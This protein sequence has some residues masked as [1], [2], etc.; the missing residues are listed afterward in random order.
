[1]KKAGVR[2]A[3]KSR[4]TTTPLD[5][6]NEK[7][8]L[9]AQQ[10]I[11]AIKQNV[12]HNIIDFR[13]D[14]NDTL[15]HRCG[16]LKDESEDRNEVDQN[17]V[18]LKYE[19]HVM[20]RL[21][22][23]GTTVQDMYYKGNR[24]SANS[25]EFSPFF[26]GRKDV[27]LY[28]IVNY[29]HHSEDV[30]EH[31][32]DNVAK[33][34]NITHVRHPFG[35]RR[36]NSES[37]EIPNMFKGKSLYE[38]I[39]GVEKIVS[40]DTPTINNVMKYRKWLNDN[41]YVK[42][43]SSC[44]G[45]LQYCTRNCNTLEGMFDIHPHFFPKWFCDGSQYGKNISMTKA[46]KLQNPFAFIGHYIRSLEKARAGGSEAYIDWMSDVF[47][48]MGKL[49]Y[50]RFKLHQRLGDTL[51]NIDMD[52]NR[53]LYQKVYDYT[54]QYKNKE[55][56]HFHL[57][58]WCISCLSFR[59]SCVRG[60]RF[61]STKLLMDTAPLYEKTT[62]IYMLE[63]L[64]DYLQNRGRDNYFGLNDI[65]NNFQAV[66]LEGNNYGSTFR[67]NTLLTM[68]IDLMNFDV[69][70]CDLPKSPYF[71]LDAYTPN[72]NAMIF[73]KD[74][75]YMNFNELR[76]FGTF[77]TQMT[78]SFTTRFFRNSVGDEQNYKPILEALGNYTD[79]NNVSK[80][81]IDLVLNMY[82]F[83]KMDKQVM[84]K[85]I[86]GNKELQLFTPHTQ[87]LTNYFMNILIKAIMNQ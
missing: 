85:N 26:F 19:I 49:F 39:E 71:D 11:E 2:G 83:S 56:H 80:P 58:C 61:D 57:E 6:I 35:S 8:R 10:P 34:Y 4:T 48:D 33:M 18:Y 66:D 45:S 30:L 22:V 40:E 15:R 17:C 9:I 43:G 36:F 76:R 14:V 87:E 55:F 73:F 32:T 27:I 42:H 65:W 44:D 20:T 28:F 54:K 41:E 81:I 79:I 3:N 31:W 13:I 12:F 50:S 86:L 5:Q 1:M 21:N 72:N 60:M 47:T 78:K 59:H 24:V 74:K 64:R 84:Y 63:E 62:T 53:E 82:E 67:T 16:G 29:E 7:M 52:D 70:S 38:F 77:F 25:T 69:M 37:N 51:N 46:M 68:T 75:T 23:Y